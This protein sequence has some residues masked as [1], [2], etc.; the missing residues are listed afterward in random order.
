[1]FQIWDTVLPI[2]T[3]I[4]PPEEEAV[5]RGDKQQVDPLWRRS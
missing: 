1:M 3:S 4:A 5:A 2:E